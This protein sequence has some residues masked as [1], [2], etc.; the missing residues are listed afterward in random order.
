MHPLWVDHQRSCL[1]NTLRSSQIHEID[2]SSE[3]IC[4]S[5]RSVICFCSTHIVKHV[6]IENFS[7]SYSSLQSF[8][9][10]FLD[11]K[12]PKALLICNHD[13][14]QTLHVNSRIGMFSNSQEFRGRSQKISQLLV[15]DLKID[16]VTRKHI[17]LGFWYTLKQI[18]IQI[19]IT[20]GCLFSPSMVAF[21]GSRLSVPVY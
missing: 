10:C 20:H 9:P 14:R 7:C 3:T 2:F 6:E 12:D 15:V 18:L 1:C 19:R 17:F 5:G 16:T 13:F 11:S 21:F 4:L 8:V